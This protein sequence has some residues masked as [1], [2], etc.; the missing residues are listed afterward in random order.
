MA[1]REISPR[2]TGG[3]ADQP[4]TRVRVRCRPRRLAVASHYATQAGSFAALPLPCGSGSE[5]A[6]ARC[7]LDTD[8]DDG[9][10]CNL[11]GAELR[12]AGAQERLRIPVFLALAQHF[13]AP[14]QHPP[15]EPRPVL[16]VAIH[17]DRD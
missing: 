16:L 15:P 6:P 8:R 17:D 13:G 11:H 2:R 1:A 3:G 7:P 5:I 10:S 9:I 12:V 14:A 4:I